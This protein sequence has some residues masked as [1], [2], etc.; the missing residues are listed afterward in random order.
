MRYSVARR[1]DEVAIVISHLKGSHDDDTIAVLYSFIVL[2]HFK[3]IRTEGESLVVLVELRIF[4]V[5]VDALHLTIAIVVR[6]DEDDSRITIAIHR[7]EVEV[8]VVM[9]DDL[10]AVTAK[11]DT[12]LAFWH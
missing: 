7:L 8:R 3:E 4:R 9:D 11:Q 12:V 2:F 10:E 5:V 6:E 1:V